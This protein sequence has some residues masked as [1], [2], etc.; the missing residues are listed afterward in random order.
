MPDPRANISASGAQLHKPFG[1]VQGGQGLSAPA[2]VPISSESAKRAAHGKSDAPAGIA[3]TNVPQQVRK[4]HD[5]PLEGGQHAA[6][7][8]QEKPH[9]SDSPTGNAQKKAPEKVRKA[10]PSSRE[11][12]Q[13]AVNALEETS[14]QSD[15]PTGPAEAEKDTKPKVEEAQEKA[16]EKE[17]DSSTDPAAVQKVTKADVKARN[18]IRFDRFA[19][20]Q[21]TDHLRSAGDVMIHAAPSTPRSGKSASPADTAETR[22][23]TKAKSEEASEK[24][25]DKEADSLAGPAE[26]AK[27]TKEEVVARNK[28]AF[29]KLAP[30]QVRDHSRVAGELIHADPSKV[31]KQKPSSKQ[32]GDID[33]TSTGQPGKVSRVEKLLGA[34]DKAFVQPFNKY[35]LKP[36]NDRFEKHVGGPYKR[37]VKPKLDEI[38]EFTKKYVAPVVTFLAKLAAVVAIKV[39]TPI[40]IIAKEMGTELGSSLKKNILPGGDSWRD[41]FRR[42]QNRDENERNKPGADSER[43]KMEAF[44]RANQANQQSNS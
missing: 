31:T 2:G 30:Q 22:K 15:S 3:P 25:V 26:G 7:A 19:A 11:G 34:L 38:V 44:H 24:K 18:K 36:V 6:N 10:H 43:E 12:D 40:A 21:V 9:Q 16:V 5:S 39:V 33:S 13:S 42:S 41:M 28:T 35:L 14:R 37:W 32:N 27:G 29:D 4:G 1:A 17:P 23:N 20:E 8:L